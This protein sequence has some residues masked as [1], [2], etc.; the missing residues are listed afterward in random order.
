M[1]GREGWRGDTEGGRGDTEGG[2]GER[3]GGRGEREGGE[4][5]ERKEEQKNGRME[6]T[7]MTYSLFPQCLVVKPA[8]IASL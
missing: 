6:A 3:E 7:L 4:E 1:G 2:R 5:G 8:Y